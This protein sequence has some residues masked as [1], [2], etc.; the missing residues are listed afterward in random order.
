MS[1]PAGSRFI[2][3][4]NAFISG[5]FLLAPIVV[6]VWAVSRIIDL[7][8]GT[9]RPLFLFFIPHP[10][11]DRPRQAVVWDNLTTIAVI[12]LVTIL[13]YVSRYFL[14]KLFLGVAERFMLRI[15]VIGSIYTTVKQMVDTFSSH[16]RHVFDKVVLV[17][18]PRKGAW[19]LGFLTGK[20]PGEAQAKT[21]EELW[22]VFI[23]TTPNPTGG[24]LILFP[25]RDVVELVM[26][27]G[28]GMKM[29]VSGGGMVPTWPSGR[30]PI[31]A[32]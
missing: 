22:S 14:G 10:L 15:P 28:E 9:F 2:S 27:V 7:I 18:F 20:R 12:A 13:G 32:R 21:G 8:G 30:P 6:T 5:A 25:A 26:T 29:I 19:T 24:Y 16:N 1:A 17:E 11:R 31:Q 4:R 3:L 23:P